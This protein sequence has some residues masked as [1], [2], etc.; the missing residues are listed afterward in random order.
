MGWISQGRYNTWRVGGLEVRARPLGQILYL[1]R[2]LWEWDPSSFYS[3]CMYEQRSKSVHPSLC[4]VSCLECL[5]GCRGSDC[6]PPPFGWGGVIID[7]F[8]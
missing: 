2:N 7:R 1:E 4:A 8:C 6:R 3:L 5:G